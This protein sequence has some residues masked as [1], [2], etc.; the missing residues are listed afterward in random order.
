MQQAFVDHDALPVRLLHARARSCSAVGMLDEVDARAGRAHVT[1]DVTATRSWTDAEIAERMSGNLCRCGAYAEHR[2]RHRAGRGGAEGR[3]EALRLPGPAR[4]GGRRA[5]P[6]PRTRDAVFL[7]GGTNL[8]DHLKLGVAGPACSSTSRRSTS[9]EIDRARGRTADRRRRP[10]QRP[11]GRPPGARALPGARPGTARPAR[12]GSCATWPPPAATRCSAPGARTSRTSPRRATSASRAAGCSAIGGY[13]RYHAILGASEHCVADAPVRH[14][15]RA[16]GPRRAGARARPGRRARRSPFADLHRLPGD[17]PDRDTVLDHGELITAIDLPAPPLARALG[18]PQG[19]RPRVVR[20]RAG[21]RRRGGRRRGRGGRATCGSRFGGVAHAPWRARRAEEA[22]RGAP[23]T[24][25][26]YRAAAEAELADARPLTGS[27]AA[28][29][30]RSRCSPARSS[31]PCATLTER[32]ASM[33]DLLEPRAI[34]RDLRPPRRAGQGHRAPR[35]RLR[36]ARR[37]ARVL[38]PRAGH[39]RARPG[40]ARSTR[41]AAEAARR[42]AGACSPRRP[43]SGWRRTDDAELAVLQDDEVAFRGQ[44]IGAGASPRPPRSPARPRDLVRGD[45]RANCR[46]TPSSRPTATTC[47][48]PTRST[49]RSPPTPRDG[50]VAAA[51]AAAARHRRADLHHGDEPQQPDGAARHDRPVGAGARTR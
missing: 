36:D 20:V 6:S 18:L 10:Q 12:P 26:S 39:H 5:Q 1:A 2:A 33:T 14:G 38:P 41:P 42:R 28:T 3:D 11:R 9:A 34:G 22:L 31:P 19:P 21:L 15:R 27:T 48:R 37:A 7:A 44:I 24:A 35:L 46:T 16:G 8:V 51:M 49:R 47:T 4:R 50:D 45:L 23:A 13:T 30:S 40:H 25:A 32:S 17:H 43:P 29:P